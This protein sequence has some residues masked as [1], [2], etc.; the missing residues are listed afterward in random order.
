MTEEKYTLKLYL[1][2]TDNAVSRYSCSFEH[3]TACIL[4]NE[5]YI[6]NLTCFNMF[7]LI[8]C[9]YNTKYNYNKR[10]WILNFFKR[11]LHS[12]SVS[13]HLYIVYTVYTHTHI[14]EFDEYTKT[15]SL[16][17]IHT[18]NMFIV[19]LW[20]RCA[21]CIQWSKKLKL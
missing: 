17:P 19:R 11:S 20:A 10:T 13:V 7:F 6:Y 15:M 8:K 4:M 3:S 5:W 16:K 12:C 1:R 18:I 2:Q 9:W 14:W 21:T